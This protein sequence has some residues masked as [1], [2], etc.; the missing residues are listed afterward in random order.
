MSLNRGASRKRITVPLAVFGFAVGLFAPALSAATIS[1]QHFATLGEAQAN[2]LAGPNIAGGADTANVTFVSYNPPASA[3]TPY[4][5]WESGVARGFRVSFDGTSIGGTVVDDVFALLSNVSVGDGANGLLL[6]AFTAQPDEGVRLDNLHLTLRDGRVFA[7]DAVA[8][9]APSDYV[10]VTTDLPLAAGFILSGAV[11]FTWSGA[12]PPP[13]DQSFS[14]A[15]VLV[16]EPAAL[17]AL[18]FVLLLSGGRPQRRA[19]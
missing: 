7:L 4:H 15:P 3:E 17:A 18:A 11:T 14:V 10:L 1:V 16:P 5:L 6:T 19:L 2:I 8:Q 12:L 13:A 9:A